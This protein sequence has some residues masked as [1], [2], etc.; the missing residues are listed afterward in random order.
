MAEAWSS[1]T[2]F[3]FLG[4]GQVQA[5]PG[6]D[7][8]ITGYGITGR[9]L[10]GNYNPYTYSTNVQYNAF[11]LGTHN[12]GHP[13]MAGVT[14]LNSN[15]ANIVTL[16]VGA[17]E[18]AQ[19]NLGNSL[20]AYRP[21]SG[22]HTTVGVTAYVGLLATQSGDWGKVIV[23]A[24][25]WLANCQG[26]SPTPTPTRTPTA[27]P[28]ATHTPTPIPTATF[29]PTPSPTSTRTPTPTATA[30][31][32]PTA[33]ATFTPTPT[34]TV[35]SPTPTSTRTPTPTVT[36]TFTPIAT[37][38]FTPT[39]TPTVPSPTP[40][41]TRTPTPTPT[42]T[43][44]SSPTP[45]P[46]PTST[47]TPT[48]VPGGINVALAA[49]G[50]VAI[51]SS[52]YSNNFPVRAV[53]DGDRLGLNWGNGGG[54]ADGTANVWPD[55][56]EID[57]DASYPINEIDFFTLQDDYANPI[58]PTLNMTFT[59]YGVTNFEV[60][61]WTGSTWADVPGGN[62]TGNNHVWRQFTFAS[63]TT[64]KIRVLINNA[65]ASYSRVTE[66]EAYRAGANPTPTPTATAS[67]SS[68]P[69]P[70]PSPTSTP[71]PTVVPGG[72]NVALAANGGVASASST[73]SNNF[74]VRAVNDG[75][76]LGLNWGNGGGWADGT[77]NV[78]PDWVEI[79]FDASYAINE[80]DFFT[81]QD[82]YQNP[83][84]P[85]LNMTFTLYG[86]T[87]F[88]VQYWTGS[89]WADVP[90]GV[91]TGNNHVWRQFTFA[92][93]TTAKIRVLIN[94]SLASYSR[95]TEIEAYRAG[96]NPTPTPTATAS[97]SS[98][99][100][101]IPSPTS[102]PT[103][104][105]VP[106]GTNVALA[107]NG[108]VASAS[109]TYSNNFPV[110]AVNDG[111]RLGLNWGN[112]GGWADGTTN[113]WPD[114]VEIDFDASYAINEIDFFT[115]QDNYQNPIPPTLNMTFTLYGVTNFEVQ[116]WT[117]STW[118]DVPG[119]VV[120]GNNHVWRQFT[121]A[122]ITTAKIRVL[123]NNSLASYSRV[124]EIEAYRAGATPTPTPTPTATPTPSPTPTPARLRLRTHKAQPM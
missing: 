118:A 124:I 81:L 24:G 117:G 77:T 92:N 12:A 76:R 80:I 95:V 3:S 73:Y 59:L 114:W 74:P 17:T 58:P 40:T 100:T 94:N 55:W 50:G 122:N 11:S 47:P 70:I 97:V 32:T 35:P 86:V 82:N 23:N 5:R 60:Q 33:T 68:S 110:R 7:G 43:V 57:F 9:W 72:T 21:V 93:I 29:T 98:S 99:P 34:P 64:A 115:L 38:T 26:G 102:T 91:V 25:N 79:D 121:F 108:G 27:T 45:I 61:Y 83:I 48:A 106:G 67:V 71:T 119:G 2:G 10:S 14:M 22:G 8:T 104:T 78:W 87:N 30:T 90:G 63:I 105:V 1:S 42:A 15:Y 123:I 56:V 88:E 16:A 89:T 4:T 107:A 36:A 84:P 62:V 69:T 44:P 109:S 113:V 41:S 19:N 54:W 28:T 96:A 65:L 20:V 120:T 53:N 37:A 49:N 85:T 75:D 31:F 51:A 101:P 6:G 39:P 18:V 111:D 103:P 66:I 13:L 112:G 52:T 46:S 116:Y